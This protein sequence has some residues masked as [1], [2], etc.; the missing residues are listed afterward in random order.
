MTTSP[1]DRFKRVDAVFDAVLD[2]PPHDQTAY[3]ERVCADEPQVRDEVRKLLEAHRSTRGLLGSRVERLSLLLDETAP[4]ESPPE[5]IGPFRI[6]R[7]IGQGGMGQVFLGERADGQFEQRVAIKLIRFPIPGL[8]RRFL[9]ERRIVARLEHPNIA[10]LID[11][12]ITDGG[13]PYFAMEFVDGEPIDRY[14]ESRALTLDDRLRLFADVCGAVSYAHHH[15]IIHRDL[16]PTNILVT[17]AGQVKLL[18]FGIAKLLGTPDATAGDETQTEYRAMTPE[19]AAPEQVRGEAISTA[20]DV[21]SLGVLLYVLVTGVKPYELRG[22]SAGEVERIVCE[23]E[24]PRASAVAPAPGRRRIRGDLDLI[25][26]T[27][28]QKA[29]QRRYQSPDAFVEDLE[30]FRG[31]HTVLARPDRLTYRMAKFVGRHRTAVA[32]AGLLVLALAAAVT[33]ERS[34]RYRAETETRKAAEVENFLVRVFEVAD[35]DSWTSADGGEVTARQLLDR[36]ATRIDSTLIDQPEV[37]AELRG[38]LGRVY[39]NL[40][41]Y[42]RA[43]PL[44]ERSLA[45]RTSLHGPADVR[46][47]ATMDQLGTAFVALDRY[48]E[49]EPLLRQALEQRRRL[50]GQTDPATVETIAHLARLLEQRNEFDSAE[51]L[52]R[53]VVAIRQALVGDSALTVADAMNDL[54]VLLYR[55][56]RAAEA[57]SL[58][59][60]ALA[61]KVPRLGESHVSTARTVQ[62]LAQSLQALER[63]E[64]A[65][66]FHRRA[67]AAKRKALGNAHPSVTISL[68]NLANLLTRMDGRLDEAETLAREAL[69]LDRQLFGDTH[70]FVGQS[71]GTVGLILR[72]KGQFLGAD[73]MF[74]QALA[75]NRT[76]HGEPHEYVASNLGNIALTRY[77]MGDG[78]AAMDF[79]RRAA[80]QYRAKLG[81]EHIATI[82][83]AGNLG[84]VLAEFGDPVEAESLLRATLD[85]LDPDRS[86]HRTPVFVSQLALGKALLA[87]RRTEEALPL[88]EQLARTARE[89]FG[90]GHVRTGEPLLLYGSALAASGRSAEAE[91]VLRSARVTLEKHRT[92]QP[93]LAR[94]AAAAVA[95]LALAR[96]GS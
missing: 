96:G 2:L 17:P 49:A 84:S 21:Y 53:E 65:E 29:P 54:G 20:T 24:P 4:D 8:V 25:I 14:C 32:A 43:T 7:S 39:A 59:R 27:A 28:L 77:L 90:E 33:R 41:L 34:L 82:T 58:Y 9:E 61:I 62:S 26:A 92:E 45:L 74:R 94:R 23:Q 75:I 72:A 70:S 83:A 52:Y 46:V 55:R 60:S 31:G 15:L 48:E 63:F 67:L 80:E 93:R 71:Y 42:D 35:P 68:N 51:L 6:V 50:L 12:G 1:N 38:V 22:R 44:L 36:G 10:R 81:D 69:A 89:R 87:Q 37:Q 47:A 76:V 66:A 64:E 19:F 95:Q 85:E 86:D 88:L 56:G 73:S 57:E 40:G 11:G 18:D 78:A 16:K 13:L 79:M 3:I 91:P 30:R 5:Q